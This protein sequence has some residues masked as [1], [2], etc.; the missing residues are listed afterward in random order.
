VT[1]YVAGECILF[2]LHVRNTYLTRLPCL[3]YKQTICAVSSDSYSEN[4]GHLNIWAFFFP[5]FVLAWKDKVTHFIDWL[6]N[7]DF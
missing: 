5:F 1:F 2:Y 6:L 4:G 3:S 7:T